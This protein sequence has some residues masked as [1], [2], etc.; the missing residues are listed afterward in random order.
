L[1]SM[2]TGVEHEGPLIDFFELFALT[3]AFSSASHGTITSET[4]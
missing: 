1:G 3:C 4:Q 2:K